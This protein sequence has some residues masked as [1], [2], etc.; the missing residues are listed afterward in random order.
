M[1]KIVFQSYANN[2]VQVIYAAFAPIVAQDCC[3][4]HIFPITACAL[5]S[6]AFSPQLGTQDSA[7]VIL[8]KAKTDDRVFLC[9]S[10]TNLS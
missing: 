3:R 2:L 8:V 10:G 7:M 4:L 1:N 9:C 6:K 5:C